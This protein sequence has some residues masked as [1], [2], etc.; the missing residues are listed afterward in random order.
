MVCGA[1]I[2]NDDGHLKGDNHLAARMFV[3]P[4]ALYTTMLEHV[5]AAYPLEACGLLG[6]EDGRAL[7]LYPV[8]NILQ[9]PTHYEMHPLQQVQAMLD[10]EAQGM[11]LLAVYHSHPH[12]PARPSPTDIALAYYP[13]ALQLIR[14]LQTLQQPEVHACTIVDGIVVEVTWRIG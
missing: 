3:I 9:S 12:G 8:D 6:G 13:E 1:K 11:A 7:R 10:I 14:S 4:Q 2:S 5:Q